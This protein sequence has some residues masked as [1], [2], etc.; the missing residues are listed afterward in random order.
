MVVECT[1]HKKHP[2]AFGQTLSERKTL[3]NGRLAH[4]RF[5]FDCFL[6]IAQPQYIDISVVSRHSYERYSSSFQISAD[7][8][9]S[10][11]QTFDLSG[12]LAVPSSIKVLYQDYWSTYNRIQTI[13]SNVSTLRSAG[14][15]TLDYYIY[16]SNNERLKFLNGQNLHINRYPASNWA[17]VSKD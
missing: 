11:S 17:A 6:R 2:G 3:A 16:E 13:N 12:F 10:M 15:K 1:K 5:Y 9:S 8:R 7:V 14:D 4:H